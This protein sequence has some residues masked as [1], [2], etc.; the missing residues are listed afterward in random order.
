MSGAPYFEGWY[1]KCR[2]CDGRS[3]ALIPAF[4]RSASGAVSASLQVLTEH[5]SWW[6]PIPA[7][8]FQ[9][10]RNPL[11]VRFGASLLTHEGLWLN[12]QQDDLSLQGTLRFGP[13]STLES[14]IMGP[15]RLLPGMECAHS[16]I[17]M[18]HTLSGI[19]SLNGGTVDFTGG[20]GYLE[21]D[22]GRSFPQTYLWTQC[23]WDGCSLMLA[24]ASV[25]FLGFSFTGCICAILL[26]GQELR[27]ATYK[28]AKVVHWSPRS[29]EVVQG[30]LRLCVELL[31]CTPHP[32]RA[33]VTGEMRRI[34]RESL[35]SSVHCR[36]WNG[37]TLLFDQTD[38][39]AGFEAA[40]SGQN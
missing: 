18:S 7:K 4:H 10:K 17:S 23:S 27:I 20:A 8:G 38:S 36:L 14:P 9:V 28:G 39:G 3:L 34:V 6:I 25:P 15:F 21:S 13:F 11:Q 40:G 35:R 29:V 37:N 12:I 33:P 32:L 16:V 2:S 22:R 5:R 26:N 19:L 31:N 30:K 1:C 24:L